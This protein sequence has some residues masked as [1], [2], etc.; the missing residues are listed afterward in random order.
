MIKTID[1]NKAA[2]EKIV[3]VVYPG[4]EYKN[5]VEYA[6]NMAKMINSGI[7][8]LGIVPE[9]CGQEI[10][11][12]ACFEIAPYSNI[13]SELEKEFLKFY[14]IVCSYCGENGVEVHKCLV[15]GSFDNIIASI[16]QKKDI[17]LV[18]LPTSSGKV[19]YTISAKRAY[20]GF[21]HCPIVAVL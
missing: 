16:A 5:A 15:N 7:S 3:V 9:I 2:L 1:I 4:I 11:S 14:D 13:S 21:S 18:V 10:A 12:M 19:D 8:L 17:N 20:S 6:S